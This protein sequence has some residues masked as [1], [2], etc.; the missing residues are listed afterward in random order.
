[1]GFLGAA[2]GWKGGGK[3][4]PSLK[5]ATHPATMKL[6]TTLPKEDSKNINY[7]THP[8]SSAEISKNQQLLLYQEIQI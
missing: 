5:G 3:N 6:C 2:H 1:M 7:V 4:A 8:L